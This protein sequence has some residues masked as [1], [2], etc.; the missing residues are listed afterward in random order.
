MFI[1]QDQSIECKK[2]LGRCKYKYLTDLEKM[3][4]FE[5]EFNL[6]LNENTLNNKE[7]ESLC[8]RC[9]RYKYK[10]LII[11]M[12]SIAALSQFL[13][14]LLQKI[15]NSFLEAMLQKFMQKNSK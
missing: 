9:F 10:C 14:L 3:E 5:E 1:F 8:V 7:N 12:L 13:Y 2:K 11:W 6:C 4:N 15:D